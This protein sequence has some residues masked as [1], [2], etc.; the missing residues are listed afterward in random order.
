MKT[1]QLQSGFSA[2]EL[3]ITLFIAG[4]FL[5]SGYQL[6][7]AVTNNSS[8]VR[9]QAAANNLANDYLMRF[10]SDPTA[11]NASCTPT[12]P[13]ITPPEMDNGLTN[14]KISVSVSCPGAVSTLN[15]LRKVEVAVKYG[16]DNP[17]KE[18]RSATYVTYEP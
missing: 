4:A 11:I 14:V 18:T 16:D 10:K 13:Q 3:L 1:Q 7:A 15:S 9:L 8:D 6:Y 12:I 2:V 5:I 17:Q